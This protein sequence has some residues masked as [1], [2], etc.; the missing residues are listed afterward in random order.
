MDQ[1]LNFQLIR[2]RRR[3]KTVSLQI[4][5][6][7]RVVIYVPYHTPKWEIEKFVKEK[8]SW[9]VKKIS[10]KERSIKETRRVFITGE[11][12]LYLGESYPLEVGDTHSKGFPLKLSFGKFIVDKNHLERARDLFILW[13]QTEAKE[14][15]EA[16]VRYFSNRLQLVPKGLKITSAKHRWGSCSRDNRLSFSWRI[17]MAPWSVIDYVVIHE[18]VHIKEKNHSKKFWDY[19]ETI[20]PEYRKHRFWLKKNGYRLWL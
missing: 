13:Y 6:E 1:Y 11:K 4:K 12:F 5:E 17:I 8:Q 10:E 3:R 9:I 16:R 19:L 2:S 14:K 7:G 20:F 18:L 15:L